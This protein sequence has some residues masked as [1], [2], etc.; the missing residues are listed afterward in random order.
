[1]KEIEKDLSQCSMY[2]GHE[3]D[4]NSVEKQF[5]DWPIN[6]MYSSSKLNR[7]FCGDWEV[8]L[9][10]C[11]NVN[12]KN[13]HGDFEGKKNK[14]EIYTIPGIK[15]YSYCNCLLSIKG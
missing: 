13:S 10:Q 7:F 3:L 6:S 8:Y 15:I 2:Y 5:S 14:V 9:N 11:G 12:D 1:M 4:G